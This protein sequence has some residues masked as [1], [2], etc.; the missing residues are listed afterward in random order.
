M[1]IWFICCFIVC[2]LAVPLGAQLP[3]LG[4]GA[5]KTAT[6]LAD[7]ATPRGTVL[8]FLN[9]A[10]SGDWRRAASYLNTRSAD[11]PEIAQQ[12]K[13]VLDRKVHSDPGL[14][15]AS[16]EGNLADGL[17]PNLELIGEVELAG[18]PF[19]LE[20]FRGRLRASRGNGRP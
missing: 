19:D 7:K 3:S 8:G 4:A 1:R 18:H 15:S 14:L 17:R 13:R 20:G 2:T 9:A 16:P 5:P 11:A 10:A 6:Q 12:F